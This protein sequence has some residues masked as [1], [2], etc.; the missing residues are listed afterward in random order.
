MTDPQLLLYG[1]FRSL[2]AHHVPL[3]VADYLDAL[4]MLK[5]QVA[6]GDAGTVMTRV[7]VRRLCEV[8]WAR[9][10]DEVRLIAR[11]LE[12]IEPPTEEEL[13]PIASWVERRTAPRPGAHGTAPVPMSP[14]P[15][16]ATTTPATTE[17]SSTVVVTFESVQDPEGVPLPYP[18]LPVRPPETYVLQPQTVVSPRALAVLWRRF[19]RMTR[20]GARTELDLDAT[21]AERLS[22]GVIDRPVLRARRVNRARLLLLAD[23]SASMAPW[24]PFLDALEDSVRLSRLQSAELWYFTNLPRPTLFRTADLTSAMP[25]AKIFERFGG[26]SVLIVSDSGAARG[27]LVSRRVTRTTEFLADINRRMQSIVWVNPLP[28]QRWE[29]TTAGAVAATK[30]IAFFP[31]ESTSMIRA[32]DVLRGLKT[33]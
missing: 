33:Y 8:L 18:V 30:G 11:A 9:T 13:G 2:L 3:G 29:G 27:A 14:L 12:S 6:R 7:A 17:V 28:R 22:R 15:S 1:V 20:S 25:A 19:R 24:R 5:T 21:I 4:R 26:A 23:A 31:L 16:L 10:P 32:V